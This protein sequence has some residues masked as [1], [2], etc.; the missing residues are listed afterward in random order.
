MD[1]T[2]YMNRALQGLIREIL[3]DVARDGL[4]GA[5]HYYI[6]FQT[7]RADVQ[8]PEWLRVKYPVEMSIVLQNQ[9]ESLK[10]GPDAFQVGLAFGGVPATLIVPYAAIKTFA[11]PSVSWGVQLTP[12]PAAEQTATEGVVDLASFRTKK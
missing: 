11:D 2:Q 5:T 8:M 10:A 7:N 12:E 9:F 1:Y 4:S 3:S 6:A